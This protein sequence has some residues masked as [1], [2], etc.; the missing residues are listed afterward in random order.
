MVI[1]RHRHRRRRSSTARGGG[2]L[3]EATTEASVRIT[4]RGDTAAKAAGPTT[5]REVFVKRPTE[6]RQGI[7]SAY[8][9]AAGRR[10]A[11]L[12]GAAKWADSCTL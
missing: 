5:A 9:E 10:G 4:R 3:V 8:D 2:G 7:S 1:V 11:S 6:A 12:P